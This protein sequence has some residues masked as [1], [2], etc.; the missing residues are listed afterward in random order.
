MPRPSRSRLYRCVKLNS[1]S[2]SRCP[3]FHVLRACL[4][5]CLFVSLYMCLSVCFFVSVCVSLPVCL[6][7]SLSVYLL[8]SMTGTCLSAVLHD[9]VWHSL[10]APT[11]LP[12]MSVCL[13]VCLSCGLFVCR[14]VCLLSA[15]LSVYPVCLFICLSVSMSVCLCAV[16]S[17]RLSVCLS[18][19]FAIALSSTILYF[20]IDATFPIIC[21]LENR[22]S[23]A[24]LLL[25]CLCICR[26]VGLR[27]HLSSY[28][29]VCVCV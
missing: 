23:E 10:R 17:V 12:Y 4:S 28:P 21:A 2:E 18:A 22:G 24:T 29:C 3:D 27:L 6:F 16:L 15:C 5:V 13:T 11:C 26:L 7:V 9:G 14:Y 19:C 8:F 25:P 1:G 20:A